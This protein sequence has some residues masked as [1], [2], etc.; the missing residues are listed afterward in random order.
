[1][2][3]LADWD[4]RFDA[5]NER[6]RQSGAP[7]PRAAGKAGQGLYMGSDVRA[8][9]IADIERVARV[10][11]AVEDPAGWL[12]EISGVRSA[13]L[14]DLTQA[15]R[16]SPADRLA[17]AEAQR[18]AA[19]DAQRVAALS[20]RVGKP[21]DPTG[22]YLAAQGTGPGSLH[23]RA[24]MDRAWMRR[25]FGDSISHSS[26]EIVPQWRARRYNC[27]AFTLGELTT[28]V[29]PKSARVLDPANPFKDVNE[30]Y[31]PKGYVL[32]QQAPR[33]DFGYRGRPKI[34]VYGKVQDGK[35]VE[36]THAAIQ[37]ADGTWTS[38]LGPDGPL[39]RHA[40][41]GAV[42]GNVLGVPVAVYE[43]GGAPGR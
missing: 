26:Y 41:P 17:Q 9:L 7:Y 19:V 5:W 15:A 4:A 31:A 32:T 8:A 33:L 34:A 29:Q 20:G 12:R 10:L 16:S 37:E 18:R 11:K 42:S 22:S 6:Q 40:T 35:I 24:Q 13:D 30:M 1:M 27:F 21:L 39:V 3:P 38:K 28:P 14:P 36:F 43:Q 25:E 23:E 2:R